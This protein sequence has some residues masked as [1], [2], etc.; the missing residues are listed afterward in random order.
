M[1]SHTHPDFESLAHLDHKKWLPFHENNPLGFR[2]R[3]HGKGHGDLGAWDNGTWD[4]GGKEL[5]LSHSRTPPQKGLP[6]YK[7]NPLGFRIKGH[8]HG[9]DMGTWGLLGDMGT[10]D[11]GTRGLRTKTYSRGHGMGVGTGGRKAWGARLNTI[12]ETTL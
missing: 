4:S 6:F 3:G 9:A 10:G 2:I 1:E 5:I 12:N 7:N 11:W 8:G